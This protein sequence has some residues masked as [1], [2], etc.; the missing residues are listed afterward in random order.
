[1]TDDRS[2]VRVAHRIQYRAI[3]EGMGLSDQ[4]VVI[5]Y[6]FRRRFGSWQRTQWN[7]AHLLSQRL[8]VSKRDFIDANFSRF[9]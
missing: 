4:V 5:G 8:L 6:A 1:V 9:A 7:V 2:Q 3:G